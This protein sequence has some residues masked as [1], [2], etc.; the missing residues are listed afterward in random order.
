MCQVAMAVMATAEPNNWNTAEDVKRAE[1]LDLDQQLDTER[2]KEVD[3]RVIDTT[4]RRG[5]DK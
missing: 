3:M 1:H 5:V 2:R 4:I